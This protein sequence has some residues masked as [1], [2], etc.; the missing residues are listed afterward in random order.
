MST[1]TYYMSLQNNS[2]T[3]IISNV[4]SFPRHMKKKFSKLPSHNFFYT[5]ISLQLITYSFFSF[6]CY[7]IFLFYFRL[8]QQKLFIFNKW[9]VCVFLYY[10]VVSSFSLS[11]PSFY[12]FHFHETHTIQSTFFYKI[13]INDCDFSLLWAYVT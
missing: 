2:F 6:F 10:F 8:G 11:L 5:F 12:C 3:G 4:L 1:H 9:Y 7:F 13:A